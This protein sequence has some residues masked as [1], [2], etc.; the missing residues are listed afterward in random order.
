MDALKEKP[1][2]VTISFDIDQ[3][4][5]QSVGCQEGLAFK[6]VFIGKRDRMGYIPSALDVVSFHKRQ[7]QS[8]QL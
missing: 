5:L 6:P 7:K 8:N 2:D 1:L 3:T 4:T